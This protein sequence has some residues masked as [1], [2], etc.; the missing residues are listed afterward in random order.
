MGRVDEAKEAAQTSL[1][2][3]RRV[4]GRP[5][6]ELNAFD[7][8]AVVAAELGQCERSARLLG[9]ADHWHEMNPEFFRDL[10]EQKSSARTLTLLV[11][12]L[13]AETRARLMQEGAGWTEDKA[14]EE[15]LAI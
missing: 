3:I 4:G 9:Y 12:A 11:S 13:P 14:A 10:N 7:H 2:E 15:A 8:L 1:R 5:N 6:Y